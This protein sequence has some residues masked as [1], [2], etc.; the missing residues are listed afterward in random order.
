MVI[1]SIGSTRT[2][3]R[4]LVALLVS[5]FSLLHNACSEGDKVVAR[6]GE[7]SLTRQ[8]YSEFVGNLSSAN[9]DNRAIL[10]SMV[11]QELLLLEADSLLADFGVQQ[12]LKFEVQSR[13]AELWQVRVIG[14]RITISAADL[15][16]EFVNSRLHHERLLRRILVR[17]DE[18]MRRVLE[19]LENGR[20][21]A[22]LVAPFAV[23]DAIA[24]G[25]GVV[26][27]F[28]HAESERRFR[29]PRRLFFSVQSR[30]FPEPIRLSRGWQ[31][32]TFV[33]EREGEL[34]EYYEEVRRVVYEREWDAAN[35]RELELIKHKHGAELHTNALRKLYDHLNGRP[36]RVADL[37]SEDAA[38]SLYTYGSE[39]MTLDNVVRNLQA[40]GVSGPLPQYERAVEVFEKLLLRPALFA[41]EAAE[42]GWEEEPEFVAWFGKMRKKALLTS[43]MERRVKSK[44]HVSEEEVKD[45]YKHN[46]SQ[47]KTLP[48]VTIRELLADNAEDAKD[49]RRQLE[50]GV[51]IASLLIRRDVET[52]GRPRSGRLQLN[53]ILAPRYPVL[54]EAAFAAEDGDWVGPLETADGHF[55]V[56]QVVESKKAEVETFDRAKDRVKGLLRQQ[57]EDQL[58]GDLISRLRR[59][60]ADRVVHY[61][62][63]ILLDEES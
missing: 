37:S 60:Y 12:H 61:P 15:E 29:I 26:G 22:E 30:E 51:N 10:Q 57:Q 19:G 41:R 32:Y 50:A 1:H 42:E 54:V 21:F 5:A 20:P 28:N 2:R 34:A 58:V 6:V 45:Y 39:A 23:N 49:F 4:C 56:F 16:A 35:R 59:K 63:R 9:G 31:I 44:I 7:V 38:L 36:L 52:H 14:P 33:D 43:L 46:S 53:P 48:S 25:D 27:W 24:E 18:D 55:A 17:S 62:D 11:D 3:S 8:D 47:F 40:T 13:L